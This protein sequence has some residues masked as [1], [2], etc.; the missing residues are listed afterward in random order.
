MVD[1]SVAE[2]EKAIKVIAETLGVDADALLEELCSQYQ[3]YQYDMH[4]MDQ[5]DALQPYAAWMLINA[6]DVVM[7]MRER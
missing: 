1:F 5:E 6:T 4:E 7:E 3:G 2:A